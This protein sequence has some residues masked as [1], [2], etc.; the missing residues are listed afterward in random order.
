MVNRCLLK[1]ISTTNNKKDS[2]NEG[3]YCD[4]VT[5]SPGER[6]ACM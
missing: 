4:N 1:I 3:V 5:I 2:D 6:C